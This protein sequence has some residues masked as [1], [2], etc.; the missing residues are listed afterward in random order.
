M[1]FSFTE[2]QQ[3]VGD[4]AAQ[5]L[6]DRVTHESLREIER[7][8]ET[9]F[10]RGTWAAIAQ[11]GLLGIALPESAGGAGLGLV[12][13]ARVLEVV[14]KTAAAL[15]VWES[16]ALGALPIAEFGSDELQAAWLGRV[17]DGSVVLTGA[18]HEDDGDPYQI[19][20][21]A[22][23]SGDGVVV[24]G[25]KICV[26]SAQLADAFV[27]PAQIDGLPGLVLVERGDGVSVEP[28]ITTSGSPDANL[29]FDGAAG[30]VIVIGAAALGRAF[31]IAVATQCALSLGNVEAMVDL[32][33]AYTKE[34][35]QFDVPIAMFQAVG[36]RAADCYIDAEGIRL[37][38]WQAITRLA[39]GLDATDE[40]SVA[41]F[42][43]AWGGQR[44]SL[45]AAH[46]HG[47][48]GVDRDY[49]LARH[50]TRAKELELQLGGAS[51][52]LL[53]VGRA[54]ATTG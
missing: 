51:Q 44:V 43:A 33:A 40:V 11:A 47:G 36:H 16:I 6:G 25:H 45:A 2:E 42:W 37:T 3:A 10:D 19:L 13:L 50:F 1:D 15:P 35:K 38:T 29:T 27:V 20:T 32:T 24:S 48:V 23:A 34:R 26:P 12:E 31:E 22:T 21:T 53:R 52:H 14:G 54:L 46:L 28:I 18:W 30:T 7:S 5:I 4:L 49:P 9:K 41:K 39:E 17:A 8:G